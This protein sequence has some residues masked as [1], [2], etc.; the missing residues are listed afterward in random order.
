MSRVRLQRK[1]V[2]LGALLGAPLAAVALQAP[3]QDVRIERVPEA[4]KGPPN[5][6]FSHWEH[7][8]QHCYACHPSVFPQANEGF[9]HADMKAGRAC[10]A[11]HDGTAAVAIS[12]LKCETCHVAR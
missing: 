8:Q 3:T 5:A 1:W 9:T 6:H 2:L 4:R 7:N 12:S 10:G 11:C